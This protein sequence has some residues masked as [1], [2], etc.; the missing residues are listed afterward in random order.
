MTNIGR[1]RR[2]DHKYSFIVEVDGF[3]SAAFNKSSLIKWTAAKVELYEGGALY[4]EREAGRITVDDVTLERG[5]GRDR[6]MYDWANQVVDFVKQ[7]G[8]VP[9][10][11]KR[12]IEVVQLARDRSEVERWTLYNAWPCE[13]E[14]GDWDNDADEVRIEKI[15]LCYDFPQLAEE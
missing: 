3:A 14:A 13:F 2:L 1:P 5:T 10:D 12:N 4:P 15:V 6:D 8:D 7:G 11:Y 9:Q